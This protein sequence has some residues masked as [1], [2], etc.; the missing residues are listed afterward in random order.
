MVAGVPYAEVRALCVDLG[1]GEKRGRKHPFAT[2]FRDL[3]AVA[4]QMGLNATMRRWNGWYALNGIGI[5][6]VPT[7]AA[8]WHWMV[9]ERTQAFGV[10]VQDPELDWPAFERAPL[11]VMYRSPATLRPSGNWVAFQ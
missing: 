5:I 3:T 9:A 7:K 4:T 11:D 8:N 10:V 2:N 1:L 6:K